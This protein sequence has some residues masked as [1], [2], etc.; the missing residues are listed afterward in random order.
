MTDPQRLACEGDS[1]LKRSW[2]TV[3][4]AFVE[5]LGLPSLLIVGFL[6][7]A[8]VTSALDSSRLAWLEP[9]RTTSAPAAAKSTA[10]RPLP[11]PT[12]STG[13]PGR[14]AHECHSPMTASRPTWT[15][16]Y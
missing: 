16:T 6:L 13:R 10:M 1:R 2:E 4:R 9:V 14:S 3:R 5:F 7:L 8:A 15:R 12:S 11:Q